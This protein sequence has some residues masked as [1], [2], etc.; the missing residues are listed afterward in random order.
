MAANC[1]SA[2]S[3]PK[4]GGSMAP[5]F[6]CRAQITKK[7]TNMSQ[8]KSRKQSD[9]TNP[10][11]ATVGGVA[12]G[13]AVG[14]LLGP[15]GAAVGAM[16]GGVAGKNAGKMSKNGKSF[17]SKVMKKTAPKI[18]A[19]AKKMKSITKKTVAKAD[20]PVSAPRKH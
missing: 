9:E 18:K 11:L 13:A 7:E 14:S 15:L 16:V 19:V 12:A 5:L 10:D 6:G 1:Q 17:S 20:K 4:S 8:S 3:S 2:G